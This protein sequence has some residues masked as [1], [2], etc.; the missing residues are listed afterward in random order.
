MF[1]EILVN[2]GPLLSA[3]KLADIKTL[4][5]WDCGDEAE[6]A[7][8][9]VVD[10]FEKNAELFHQ[11]ATEPQTKYFIVNPALHALGYIFS[12][13]EMVPIQGDAKA[14]VDYTLFGAPEDFTEVEPFRSSPAFFRP[15]IALAQSANWGESLDVSDDPEV[16]AQQ[17]QVVIDVLLRF[18]GV[19]FGIV[20]NGR[21]WRL[22]HRATSEK[23]TTFAEVD[24]TR[25]S[26]DL[27][28]F[29]LFYVLFG[30]KS[31]ATNDE[32]QSF[33]HSLLA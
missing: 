30:S 6:I 1:D 10:A 3:S 31:L 4:P 22:V 28:S 16:A 24:L 18:S 15:A 8:M 12:I 26:Q 5:E 23:Y 21:K 20:T 11:D 33:V 27:E 2:S 17:P 32:G 7:R 19:H 14:S 9:A 25:L 13:D 29:K